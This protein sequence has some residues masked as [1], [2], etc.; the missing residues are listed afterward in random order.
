MTYTAERKGLRWFGLVVRINEDR[1]LEQILGARA[2][3]KQ[4]EE[5]LR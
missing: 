1:R 5:D 2:E 4:E 3:G